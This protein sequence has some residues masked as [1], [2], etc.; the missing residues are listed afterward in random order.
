MTKKYLFS[1]LIVLSFFAFTPLQNIQAEIT[2]LGNIVHGNQTQWHGFLGGFGVDSYGDVIQPGELVQRIVFI[3]FGVLG[4]IAVVLIIYAGFLW[5]TAGGEESKAKQGT[6]LM[7][8]AIV[9]L[10]IILA[11]YTLA[12]FILY[13]LTTAISGPST[14]TPS[15]LPIRSDQVLPAEPGA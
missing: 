7:F 11:A 5:L 6:T 4:L 3:F 10:I 12:Y 15:S 8:Q 13:M 9:G 14:Q 2:T 1:L